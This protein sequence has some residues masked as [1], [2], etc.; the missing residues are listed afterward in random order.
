MPRGHAGR[1]ESAILSEQAAT[2]GLL[3]GAWLARVQPMGVGQAVRTYDEQTVRRDNSRAG[4]HMRDNI[5]GFEG[6]VD[7]NL[8]SGGGR[9]ECGVDR[10]DA[11]GVPSAANP[12]TAFARGPCSEVTGI[13][14]PP[15]A[16][17]TIAERRRQRG[18]E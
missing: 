11:A 14:Q 18:H 3:P 9:V 12:E 4:Q 16:H 6:L 2:K 15:E 10:A 17:A 7:G 1:K 13:I 8:Q 5:E